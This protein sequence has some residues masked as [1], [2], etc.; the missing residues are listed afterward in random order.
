MVN[1][2]SSQVVFVCGMS[3]GTA[4]EAAFALKTNRHTILLDARPEAVRFWTSLESSFLHLVSTP[5]EAVELAARL[6]GSTSHS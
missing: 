6:L 5:E 3:S 2:L 4:S 1:V